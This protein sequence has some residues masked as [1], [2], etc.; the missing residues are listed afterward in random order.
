MPGHLVHLGMISS[1]CVPHDSV[2]SHARPA[3]VCAVR[4]ARPRA[5]AAHKVEREAG[6]RKARRVL[7]VAREAQ[8]SIHDLAPQSRN[9]SVQ[10]GYS[11]FTTKRL[12][13]MCYSRA[14]AYGMLTAGFTARCMWK[15]LQEAAS[16]SKL[17]G[18]RPWC[19]H[20]FLHHEMSE[21]RGC[22][23]IRPAGD[24]S[25]RLSPGQRVSAYLLEA[26]HVRVLVVGEVQARLLRAD[27]RVAVHQQAA[28]V[29]Q[30]RGWQPAAVMGLSG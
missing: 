26:A 22:G 29:H 16:L 3:P 4:H 27:G 19:C 25:R 23:I 28:V 14:H 18:T 11:G 15:I 20:D 5:L 6:R 12:T 9:K 17:Q 7:V 2:R 21:M 10:R 13:L 30:A 8:R 24:Q 1:R